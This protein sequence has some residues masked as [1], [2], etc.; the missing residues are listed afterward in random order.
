M[1][2]KKV[3]AGLEGFIL[4]QG[5][6]INTVSRYEVNHFGRGDVSGGKVGSGSGENS[7]KIVNSAYLTPSQDYY[8][9]TYY[10][11]GKLGK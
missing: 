6:H 1:N 4:W 3:Y 7:E 8:D 11:I 2:K 10:L 5:R 9:S